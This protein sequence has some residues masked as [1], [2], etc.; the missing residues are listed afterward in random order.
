MKHRE[1]EDHDTD[2]SEN[3]HPK[4]TAHIHGIAD[5]LV[6]KLQDMLLIAT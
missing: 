3:V 6:H 5:V 4:T 2:V 1:S